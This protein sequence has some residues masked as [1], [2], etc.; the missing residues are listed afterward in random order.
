MSSTVSSDAPC[1]EPSPE[2]SPK[3]PTEKRRSKGILTPGP[4]STITSVVSACL[5]FNCAAAANFDTIDKLGLAM[6]V[7]A[8]TFVSG[9]ISAAVLGSFGTVLGLSAGGS[10]GVLAGAALG[11]LAGNK[12][13]KIETS[14]IGGVLGGVVFSSLAAIT[15]GITLHVTGFFGGAYLG[16]K[17]TKEASLRY[18]FN[19]GP[20]AAEAAKI[21]QSNKYHNNAA[22]TVA[23]TKPSTIP[24]FGF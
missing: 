16:H 8:G 23:I 6:I 13:K 15:L 14:A 10:A 22:S 7:A 1:P 19:T 24:S 17:Y 5:A 12:N 20:A 9:K 18:I 2:P 4:I 11:A 3:S 21:E